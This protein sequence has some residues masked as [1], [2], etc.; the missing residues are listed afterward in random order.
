MVFGW[1]RSGFRRRKLAQQ[2]G[3]T[4][5]GVTFGAFGAEFALPALAIT[6]SFMSGG[7]SNWRFAI[8]FTGF[9]A[10]IYGFV[11]IRSVEDTPAGKE[12]KKPKKSGSLE[13]TSVK[14][15]Y[16]MLVMNFGLI[17]ALG[18]LAWRL[19]RPAL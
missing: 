9:I 6:A 4:A 10:L 7:A 11:Y 12:Y 2:K 15:F 5:A 19:A 13:V 16:A 1:C 14:S 17:F 8:A 18:L 3:S